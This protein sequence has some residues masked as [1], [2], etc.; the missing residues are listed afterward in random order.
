MSITVFAV[1]TQ[2]GHVES[3]QR[4]GEAYH[5]HVQSESSLSTYKTT[6]CPN[7]EHSRFLEDDSLL[8]TALRSSLKY[9]D[10]SDVRTVSIIIA[11]VVEAVRT[12]ETSVFF[13]E[14]TL[15]YIS[16]SCLHI[17]RRENLKSHT[18]DT[19]KPR[20]PQ[21]SPRWTAFEQNDIWCSLHR[22]FCCSVNISA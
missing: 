15:R 22:T 3:R 16:E 8:W 14:T 13:I 12:R 19:F 21:M 5:C 11:V 18:I 7:P 6:R 9:T 10:V 2:C 1:V 20:E 4:F 17:Q